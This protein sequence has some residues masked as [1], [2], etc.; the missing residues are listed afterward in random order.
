MA[1]TIEYNIKVNDQGAV[2]TIQQLEDQLKDLNEEIKDVD[3]NSDVFQRAAASI[4]QVTRELEEA[5]LQLRGLTDEDKIRGF[6]GAIDVIGGSVAGLT[7]A[8]GLLG[9][10]NEEFEKYTA[11]AANAIAFSE[12]IRTAAQGLV[13][14]RQTLK[15]AGGAQAAFNAIVAANPYV[16]VT[17]AI[18]AL[19]AGFVELVHRTEPLVS[20][21][22][23]LKNLFLSF[24]NLAKFAGLQTE[25]LTKAN[26]ELAQVDLEEGLQDQIAV[27]GAYG[28]S[29]IDLEIQLAEQR[30]AKLE[31]G[32]EG[33]REAQRNLLTLRAKLAKEQQDKQIEDLEKARQKK[34]EEI[35]FAEENRK[36]AED[37]F[38]KIGEEDARE[39]ARGVVQG[40]DKLKEEGA[41]DINSIVFMDED[42]IAL[43]EELFG[44]NGVI[45]NFQNGLQEAIDETIA[46]KTNW[47]NFINIANEAFDNITN[48][49]QQR[50]ERSLINLERERNEII[51]NTSLTEEQRTA[52]LEKIAEKERE[53]EIRRIKAERDQFTLQQT[54]LIAQEV[55]KTKFFVAEQVRIAKLSVAQGTATAKQLAVDA[56]ASTAKAGM[57]LGAFVAALGPFGIAAF[58][59]SIGG[60]LAT[61]ISARRKA[62]SQIA[63]L[64]GA[65][66]G[67]GG[68]TTTSISVPSTPASA[69]APPPVQERTP[70]M[71][72]SQPSVR[73]YVLSGD[74]SSN[75][76]AD[77]KLNTKRTIS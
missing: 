49:S 11:Y 10:E 2:R 4:Q 51:A 53:L 8:I 5:Q 19:V 46:N 36:F 76:E 67:G 44:E 39:Y 69:V 64:S 59:L 17:A 6:Q 60:I 37:M 35:L 14:L 23:T 45:T 48:L 31:E 33:Y 29:T 12:G 7:G 68:A 62:Q 22:E 18:A 1:N 71:L 32:E 40:F 75:Q 13:D 9:I 63:A 30:L 21:L 20:R 56:A 52:A 55:M 74:V 26:E 54:L 25:S 41:L 73:A 47:D 43:E 27:L 57:S 72:T 38:S 61:I 42:E 28:K 65:S 58:A 77:A 3:V 16:I 24:G 15:A 34:L 66:P 50:Y 70:Q